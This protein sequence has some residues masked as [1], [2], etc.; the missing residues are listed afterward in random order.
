MNAGRLKGGYDGGVFH[1]CLGAP[2]GAQGDET[3]PFRLHGRVVSRPRAG[4]FGHRRETRRWAGGTPT[5]PCTYRSRVAHLIRD[6]SVVPRPSFLH[7]HGWIF[8]R[9][10]VHGRL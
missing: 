5:L 2:F 1:H 4:T 6:L 8:Q 7:R 3:S 9:S 10:K